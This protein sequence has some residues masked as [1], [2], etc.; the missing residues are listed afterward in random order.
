M[1]QEVRLWC[2]DGQDQL[3]QCEQAALNL[4]ERLEGW[5]T[6]DIA[7]LGD[8]LLIIG[9]QVPTAYGGWID[10]LCI[11]REGDLVIVELKRDKTPREITAQTLDY[12][13]WV[14]DLSRDAIANIAA[15]YFSD[16]KTLEEAFKETFSEELP[17]RINE[18]HRMLIVASRIDP[19]SER[20][21]KYLSG[22]YGVDINAVTF[23]YLKKTDGT[24]FL[25]RVF[26]I[27]PTEVEYQSR[28][29]GS[30]KR[31]KWTKRSEPWDEKSF[32]SKLQERGNEIEVR[33]ARALFDWACEKLHRI[34]YGS[35]S[36]MASFIPVIEYGEVWFSPFRA[37]TGYRAAYVEIPLG[38]AGMKAAPFHDRER[39]LELVRRLNEIPGIHIA[40]DVSRYPSIDL[41]TL[42]EGD[43]LERFLAVMKLAVHEV[44]ISNRPPLQ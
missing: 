18:D 26:L 37:F 43:R 14:Q 27:D 3:V 17:D 23:Q 30:S 13:S 34:A 39:K 41:I 9:R 31:A 38:G 19:S 10:L 21:I 11:D 35:G 5:L 42:A 7:I 1:P 44:K 6:R 22:N 28:A 20:I 25:A 4:E 40:E 12:A 2:V 16:A 8:D 24:E 36:Q 32:F 33:T 15:G 29:K